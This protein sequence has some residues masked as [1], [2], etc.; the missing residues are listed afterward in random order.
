MLVINN[1]CNKYYYSL[2]MII[3]RSHYDKKINSIW[4]ENNNE[5]FHPVNINCY[6]Q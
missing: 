3:I 1:Y 6:S 4:E 5:V 2:L